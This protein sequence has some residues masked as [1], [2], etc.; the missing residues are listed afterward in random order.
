LG[1]AG[2]GDGDRERILL[3]R[4]FKLAGGIPKKNTCKESRRMGAKA[5][6]K[7]QGWGR[8]QKRESKRERGT[9]RTE[10]FRGEGRGGGR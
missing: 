8:D 7:D 2:N 6:G 9:S 10:R 3:Y 4:D 5:R 1:E